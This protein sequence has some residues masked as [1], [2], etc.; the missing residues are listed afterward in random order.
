MISCTEFIPAYSELFKTLERLGGEEAVQHFWE[1]LSDTYLDNLRDLVEEHG[2]RGCFL[3]WKGSLC[4]EAADFTM[5]VD[6]EEGVFRSILNHCPSMGM[7]LKEEHIT[8]YHNYCEHCNVLYSRVLEPLGYT[9]TKFIEG[10][11]PDSC[12]WEVRRKESTE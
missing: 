2:I 7:L 9:M 3:Y 11:T 6:E 12:G 5:E 4:E 10:D 1:G 8:P